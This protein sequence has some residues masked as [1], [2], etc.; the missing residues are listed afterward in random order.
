[1]IQERM[2]AFQQNAE[3][4]RKMTAAHKANLQKKNNALGLGIF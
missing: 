2:E 4:Y 1:M 3:E